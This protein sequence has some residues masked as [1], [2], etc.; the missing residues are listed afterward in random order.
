LSEISDLRTE[1]DTL[2]TIKKIESS[3]NVM[4]KSSDSYNPNFVK[5]VLEI[6]LK[7]AKEFKLDIK[8][9]NDACLNSL[10]QSLGIMLLEEYII[11]NENDLSHDEYSPPS[12]KRIKYDNE[13]SQ[14]SQVFI[15]FSKISIK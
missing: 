10:Q 8:S 15:Y 4:L 13:S 2:N 9:V 3:F 1:T 7:H 14:A 11:L 12:S 5:C 6:A